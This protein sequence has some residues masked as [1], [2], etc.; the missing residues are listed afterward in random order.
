MLTNP[1]SPGV[2]KRVTELQDPRL[3]EE[4]RRGAQLCG[5]E[6]AV[7]DKVYK[8]FQLQPSIWGPSGKERNQYQLRVGGGIDENQAT[9]VADFSNVCIHL[10]N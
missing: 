5:I 4:V 7:R 6:D 9:M 2:L 1:E 3:E 8:P 10:G